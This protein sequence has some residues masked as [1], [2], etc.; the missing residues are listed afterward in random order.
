MRL[1]KAVK[2]GKPSCVVVHDGEHMQTTLAMSR[3]SLKPA[4]EVYL[5]R[6]GRPYTSRA[7]KGRQRVVYLKKIMSLI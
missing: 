3:M 5:Q 6:G 1:I 4:L 7:V 2:E